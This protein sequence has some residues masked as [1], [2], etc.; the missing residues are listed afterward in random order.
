[1]TGAWH[2]AL[3]SMDLGATTA[4][5]YIDDVQSEDFTTGP[6]DRT[7]NFAHTFFRAGALTSSNYFHGLMSF[8]FMDSV[9][10]LDLSVEANRRKFITADNKPVD[11]GADGSGA[12]GVQP[13]VYM[14]DGDPADNKGSAGNYTVSGTLESVAG[15]NG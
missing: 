1:M 9:N 7:I 14:P 13:A 11:L 6:I 8:I 4:H 5:L 12:F 10:Y 15:P 3:F 2:S